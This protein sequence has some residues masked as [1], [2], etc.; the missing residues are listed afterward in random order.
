MKKIKVNC[1]YQKKQRNLKMDSMLSRSDARSFHQCFMPIVS[2][3]ILKMKTD[4]PLES[5]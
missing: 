4:L 2:Q 1:K 5:V 3:H